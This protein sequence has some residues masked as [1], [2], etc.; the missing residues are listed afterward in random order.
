V[1]SVI[2]PCL[3][4]PMELEQCLQ[5]LE[6]QEGDLPFEAVVVDSAWDEEVVEAVSRFSQVRL[7]RSREELSAGA[8]RNLGVRS[9][10]ADWLAFLDADCVPDLNWVREACTSLQAGYRLCGGPVLDLFPNHPVAWAD[11][12]LQ[13]ADFQAGRPSG[14]G[15]YFPGCNMT[16]T[17]KDFIAL[18]GFNEEYLSGED[19]LLASRAFSNFPGKML[20]NPNLIVRHRGRTRWKDFLEHQRVLGYR[21]SHSRLHLNAS[22]VWMVRH[23]ALAGLVM[24]RRLGYISLRTFQYNPADL[25]RMVMFFPWLSGG[26]AAWV[27][28]FYN[29][30]KTLRDKDT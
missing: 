20:F 27:G 29:G 22:Y 30:Y 5:G 8:A 28:G 21:R 16:M 26:L 25:I 3:G 24:L 23:S 13:F 7:V 2:I 9:S 15:T 17:R 14:Q 11:N 18:G 19:I 12:H 4:Q 10:A 1:L 6:R